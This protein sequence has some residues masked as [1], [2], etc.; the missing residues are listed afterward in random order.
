MNQGFSF[1]TLKSRRLCRTAGKETVPPEEYA[2][3]KNKV[4]LLYYTASVGLEEDHIYLSQH[5]N[6]SWISSLGKC[7]TCLAYQSKEKQGETEG[8]AKRLVLLTEEMSSLSPRETSHSVI[9]IYGSLQYSN[10][11]LITYCRIIYN[12]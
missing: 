3:L 4:S 8:E 9:Y 2:L 1:L 5:S 12:G 7:E 6:H 10:N 11:I